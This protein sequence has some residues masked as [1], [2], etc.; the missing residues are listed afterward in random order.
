MKP[1]LVITFKG[2]NGMQL[3]YNFQTLKHRQ[4]EQLLLLLLSLLSC[5]TSVVQNYPS[6]VRSTYV[7]VEEN[8]NG[9]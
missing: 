6:V 4:K 5:S 8:S 9:L 2:E 3:T 1:K 7:V